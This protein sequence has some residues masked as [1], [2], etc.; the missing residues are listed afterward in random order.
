VCPFRVWTLKQGEARSKKSFPGY[1][2]GRRYDLVRKFALPCP[3]KREACCVG[4]F[5][6]DVPPAIGTFDDGDG[7]ANGGH[8]S[9]S[10]DLGLSFNGS[11][12]P[13]YSGGLAEC[14]RNIFQLWSPYF[15]F[16]IRSLTA[17]RRGVFGFG[18]KRFQIRGVNN[19]IHRFFSLLCHHFWSPSDIWW[20]QCVSLGCECE[21]DWK[22]IRSEPANH[23]RLTPPP[24]YSS[25]ATRGFCIGCF[26]Q[27]TR[28]FEYNCRIAIT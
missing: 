16:I 1:V 2:C 7:A 4:I 6:L 20:V 26:I 10:P 22:F 28:K 15:R 11:V 18:G 25:I 3:G 17:E 27:H 21:S 23:S 14:S 8:G 24:S 19:C 13:G 5:R 9:V 12:L